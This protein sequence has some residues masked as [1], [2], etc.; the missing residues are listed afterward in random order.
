MQY[1]SYI[2]V[3]SIHFID[4]IPFHCQ[5]RPSLLGL[6]PL[7]IDHIWSVYYMESHR[8]IKEWTRK[9]YWQEK[10]KRQQKGEPSIMSLLPVLVS[11]YSSSEPWTDYSP[12]PLLSPSVSISLSSWYSLI[13]ALKALLGS[14]RVSTFEIGCTPAYT[15]SI[16]FKTII[17]QEDKRRKRKM[18]HH[19]PCISSTCCCQKVGVVR[20]AI[21]IIGQSPAWALHE[22]LTMWHWVSST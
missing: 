11:F 9:F 1:C 14:A 20:V 4:Y 12:I 13:A 8:H 16:L 21:V 5:Y 10:I 18:Y 3:V 7:I 6:I 2:S 15:Q 17:V 22:R 19:V